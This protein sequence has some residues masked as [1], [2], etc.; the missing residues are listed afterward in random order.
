[1]HLT[2]DFSTH[3][4]RIIPATVARLEFFRWAAL[5]STQRCT[6]MFRKFAL[7]RFGRISVARWKK[8]RAV[9]YNNTR[10]YRETQFAFFKRKKI[11]GQ[12]IASGLCA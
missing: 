7:V 4:V 3:I 6:M 9:V 2:E 1:M 5:V 12:Q 10:Q 8:Y 11:Y